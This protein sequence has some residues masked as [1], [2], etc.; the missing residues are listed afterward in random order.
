MPVLQKLVEAT[1]ESAAFHVRQGNQRL[2]LYRVNSP[3]ILRDH[4]NVGDLLPLDHGAGGRVLAAYAGAEG[5]IYA[6]IRRNQL[7]VLL[8]DRVP[9]VA[10]IAAPVFDA[11]GDCIGALSLSMPVARLQRKYEA[12]V[13]AAA[14]S[15]TIALGYSSA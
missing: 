5:S 13:A 15:L 9:G 3:H 4:T 7:T 8:N 10:G 12:I 11:G 14:R 2:C 1:G 6:K